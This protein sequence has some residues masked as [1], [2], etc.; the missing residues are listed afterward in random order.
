MFYLASKTVDVLLE[1]WWWCAL[2][3]AAAVVLRRR[4]RWAMAI[5]ALAAAVLVIFSMPAT[6]AFLWNQLEAGVEPAAQWPNQVDALVLL[7][8]AVDVLGSTDEHVSWNN[9][10]ERLSAAVELMR[11]NR[12]RRVIVSGASGVP[13]LPSEAELFRRELERAGV[14]AEAI[15]VEPLARNTDEN[16]RNVAELLRTHGLET[17]LVLTSAYHVP[18]ARLCF[19][20]AHVHADY[21]PVDFRMRDAQRESSLLPRAHYLAKSTEALREFAGRLV[22]RWRYRHSTFDSKFIGADGDGR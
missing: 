12:A 14:D 10:Q 13:W 17:V 22:Y 18:R 19:A 4:I 2:L 1:P 5:T 11:A 16:A 3:C 20:A 9:N 21:W 8:G 7:G 6:A 15:I